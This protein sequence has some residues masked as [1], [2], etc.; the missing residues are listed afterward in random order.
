MIEVCKLS[1]RPC[2]ESSDPRRRGKCCRCHAPLEKQA[3]DPT[4]DLAFEAKFMEHALD[5]A[6]RVQGITN[7][8]YHSLVNHRLDV[9]RQRYGDAAFLDR[10]NLKEVR[11]ETPD[12]AAYAMLELQRQRAL[13]ADPEVLD[14]IYLD[15]VGAAAY[16]S[17]ADWFVQRA[18]LKLRGED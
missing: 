2:V 10:D 17:I 5:M 11:E 18:T 13:G 3:V 16:A 8:G 12:V 9:G 4:R 1:E 15:L 14:A 7:H 6:Q